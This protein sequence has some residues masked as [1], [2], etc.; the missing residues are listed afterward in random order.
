MTKPIVQKRSLYYH[1]LSKHAQEDIKGIIYRIYN[2]YN[3]KS[4]ITY[5]T[6]TNLAYPIWNSLVNGKY[7]TTNRNFQMDYD[8]HMTSFKI[9]W[10]SVFYDEDDLDA[11][12]RHF[13]LFY[14]GIQELHLYNLKETRKFLSKTQSLFEKNKSIIKELQDKVFSL[15][16]E[17]NETK[18]K[19]PEKVLV[20]V[21]TD[22]SKSPTKDLF[23]EIIV[24]ASK[25]PKESLLLLNKIQNDI[26]FGSINFDKLFDSKTEEDIIDNDITNNIIMNND[27]ITKSVE[28]TKD[29]K[30]DDSAVEKYKKYSFKGKS[31]KK[32]HK[33]KEKD[34]SV[35]INL[36]NLSEEEARKAILANWKSSDNEPIENIPIKDAPLNVSTYETASVEENN[37]IGTTENILTQTD[38]TNQNEQ[39]DVK[40]F[41]NVQTVLNKKWELS[42]AVE[43]YN[44]YNATILDGSKLFDKTFETPLK[45]VLSKD[46]FWYD[47]SMPIMKWFDIYRREL[48]KYP[49]FYKQLKEEVNFCNTNYNQSRYKALV[50]YLKG[51]TI[52]EMQKMLN[53]D[54]PMANVDSLQNS[55]PAVYLVS[56]CGAKT[57]RKVGGQMK[58]V[59]KR[60]VD[61]LKGFGVN[62]IPEVLLNSCSPR[63]FHTVKVV[64]IHNLNDE[65]NVQ[66]KSKAYSTLKEKISKL[67]KEQQDEFYA[68]L[69]KTSKKIG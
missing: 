52:E 67:S 61:I 15:T 22:I 28:E 59:Y 60:C 48:R 1:S 16:T 46:F 49:N 2:T 36:S 30:S 45:T 17:L 4:Y 23:K 54:K 19:P 62:D 11:Q 7:L 41:E 9:E 56:G 6:G 21:P 27:I 12:I 40:P 55:L 63:T 10:L 47:G 50:L 69:E 24:R 58:T 43:Q 53:K 20:E 13:R 44:E 32:S 25:N 5:E 65:Q 51:A 34:T 18:A 42:P 29:I 35:K 57:N 64:S 14:G 26:L 31:F 3:G 39:N 38:D 68:I 66:D 8:N 37:I 33:R